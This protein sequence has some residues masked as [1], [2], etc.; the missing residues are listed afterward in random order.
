MVEALIRG[1]IH[2]SSSIVT[3]KN[4]QVPVEKSSYVAMTEIIVLAAT[5]DEHNLTAV[6][7]LTFQ[8]CDHR[9]RAKKRN[10]HPRQEACLL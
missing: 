4:F 1:L 5:D 9:N 8:A 3:S 10:S 2:I 7:C 6:L